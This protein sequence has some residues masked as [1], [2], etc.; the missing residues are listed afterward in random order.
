MYKWNYSILLKRND[1]FTL[2]EKL[3][4]ILTISALCKTVYSIS[5]R[6]LQ[7]ELQHAC[8]YMLQK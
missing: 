2:Q 8:F 1:V 5:N 4:K 7:T 6:L 3:F